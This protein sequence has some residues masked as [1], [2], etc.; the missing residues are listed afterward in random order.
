MFNRFLRQASVHKNQRAFN[1]NNDRIASTTAGHAKDRRRN[2]I[3]MVRAGDER[4]VNAVSFFPCGGLIT[5]TEFSGHNF[6]NRSQDQ[7]L[8]YSGAATVQSERFADIS[9]LLPGVSRQVIW[10]PRPGNSVEIF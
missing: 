3:K 9:Q 10:S 8:L 5:L 6:I 7:A 1:S 4:K 2:Q